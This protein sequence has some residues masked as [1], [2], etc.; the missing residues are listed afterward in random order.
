MVKVGRSDTVHQREWHGHELIECW[1]SNFESLILALSS[2]NRM[3]ASF[4]GDLH[5]I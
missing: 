5:G 2:A 1:P 4:T 3:K